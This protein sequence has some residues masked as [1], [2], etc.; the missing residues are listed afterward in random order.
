MYRQE[1]FLCFLCGEQYDLEERMPLRLGCMHIY[2][3]SCL[4]IHVGDG[5]A[6]CPQHDWSRTCYL[7]EIQE[8]LKATDLIQILED[9][10][11][12]CL[13]HDKNTLRLSSKHLLPVCDHCQIPADY[14]SYTAKVYI[15]KRFILDY[16][17]YKNKLSREIK[18]EV[19][20]S[21]NQPF[22]KKLICLQLMKLL[23]ETSYVCIDHK[24]Q[25][26]ALNIYDYSLQC[27][28]CISNNQLAQFSSLE[29]RFLLDSSRFFLFFDESKLR[30][31]IIDLIKK[32]PKKSELLTPNL[33]KYLSTNSEFSMRLVIES[34]IFF[35]F[36]WPS[37]I[38]N[39]IGCQKC[40]EL[41][42]ANWR[43]PIKL[44]CNHLVCMY[45][46]NLKDMCSF[47][48]I[49]QQFSNILC[50]PIAY[51]KCSLCDQYIIDKMDNLPFKSLCL[52]IVC[53][54][55]AKLNKNC[56][57]LDDQL[58]NYL[59]YLKLNHKQLVTML[60]FFPEYCM[61]CNTNNAEYLCLEDSKFYCSDCMGNFT[62]TYINHSK[63]TIEHI[64]NARKKL[65]QNTHFSTIESDNL[66]SEVSP[67]Y[68]DYNRVL[69]TFKPKNVVQDLLFMCGF[70]KRFKF[71]YPINKKDHR[72][73]D[74]KNMP[75]KPF[76]IIVTSNKP[77]VLLGVIVAGRIDLNE[78]SLM[79]SLQ[80]ENDAVSEKNVNSYGKYILIRFLSTKA[81]L[82]HRITITY[83]ENYMIFSGKKATQNIYN[84]PENLEFIINGSTLF[85][86]LGGPILEIV[87]K[88]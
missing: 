79:A 21:F 50:I 31:M 77:I 47:C 24:E 1:D 8:E 29:Q 81:A 19:K 20:K 78:C 85:D 55:C 26:V 38:R 40:G 49:P 76:S 41:F 83:R 72:I 25:A 27:E 74:L 34:I 32:D 70:I 37:K 84:G 61:I 3:L 12:R 2:C 10:N 7:S 15:E 9:I 35:R 23:N 43:L 68:Y 51:P 30:Y 48:D 66:R 71:I 33:A 57:C 44:N 39:E 42:N 73:L 11:M 58:E 16:I 59:P 54:I 36:F 6:S 62:R 22:L 75:N 60:R 82:L 18:V 56:N 87:Y 64:E 80:V 53:S 13:K 5:M 86:S 67:I 63:N 45:C 14:I 52:C 65:F 17:K 28:L 46:F 4:K 69:D 88:Y